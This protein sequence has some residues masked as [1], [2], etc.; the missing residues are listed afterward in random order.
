VAIAADAVPGKVF[1]QWTGDVAYVASAIASPTTVTM[2]S[3]AVNL[4]ATYS[5]STVYYTL[6]GSAGAHGTVSPTSTKRLV[7]QQ[8]E[9]C[10]QRRMHNT[11]IASLTTNGTTV[12][13]LTFGNNST[14]TNFIWS[15]VQTTGVL[16]ATFTQQVTNLSG[17]TLIFAE[18][19]EGIALGGSP[20]GVVANVTVADGTGKTGAS[21]ALHLLDLSTNDG[22]YLEYNLSSTGKE[23]GALH[24]AFDIYNNNAG[25]MGIDRAVLFGIG[26]TTPP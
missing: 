21:H 24:I 7:R 1:A 3:N 17:G 11:G 26:R 4:T 15:N 16:S 8:R 12:A 14:N 22:S 18:S 20:T 6:T 25:L 5:N 9:F 13:G 19:F 10:H 2:P 23:Y